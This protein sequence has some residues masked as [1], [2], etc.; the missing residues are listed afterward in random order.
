MFYLCGW[1]FQPPQPPSPSVPVSHIRP[2]CPPAGPRSCG[3]ICTEEAWHE[4]SGPLLRRHLCAPVPRS[5]GPQVLSRSC[6]T[7]TGTR[8]GTLVVGK[9]AGV[10]TYEHPVHKGW[11]LK[12]VDKSWL[13]H[14]NTTRVSHVFRYLIRQK[15]NLHSKK[16]YS[17]KISPSYLSIP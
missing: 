13:T 4:G 10:H 5:P 11:Q 16:Q 6:Q 15:F 3:R 2:E 17:H 7:E 14:V 12:R 8:N 1:H 9:N